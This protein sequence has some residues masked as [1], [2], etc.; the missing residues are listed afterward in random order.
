MLSAALLGGTTA[1]IA[2]PTSQLKGIAM[3]TDDNWPDEA[4]Q[5]REDETAWSDQQ[6]GYAPPP[7]PGMS[8]GMKLL[9]FFLC[10]GGVLFLLCCGSVIWLGSQMD[11]DVQENPAAARETTT[12]IAE[13]EIP[14]AFEPTASLNFDIIFFQMKMAVYKTQSGE[15]GLFLLQMNLPTQ[16]NEEVE[17]ELRRELQRRDI[18]QEDLIV[19]DMETRE[20]DFGGD[21]IEFTFAR[22]EDDD[23]NPYRQISGV[24]PGKDGTALLLIQVPEEDYDEGQVVGIIQSIQ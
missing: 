8:T 7:K 24:F 20:F 15:G 4:N 21:T 13:I 19:K 17:A 12:E 2:L 22:A 10:A 16:Q 5:P 23:G 14:E 6:G 9:I 18:G 11:F 1:S 3:S